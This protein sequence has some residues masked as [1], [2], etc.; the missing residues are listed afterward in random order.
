MIYNKIL[1]QEKAYENQVQIVSFDVFD[2]NSRLL[3]S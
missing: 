2:D 1:S 3:L